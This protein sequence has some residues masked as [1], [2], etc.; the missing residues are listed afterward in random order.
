MMT[1]F[2]IN[3]DI[4]RCE[5]TL[6]NFKEIKRFADLQSGDKVILYP[7]GAPQ[8]VSN[9]GMDEDMDCMELVLDQDSSETE[10]SYEFLDESDEPFEHQFKFIGEQIT[11]GIIIAATSVVDAINKFAFIM[12]HYNNVVVDTAN[13]KYTVSLEGV[14]FC[15]RVGDRDSV[16]SHIVTCHDYNAD[17]TFSLLQNDA[18]FTA[19]ELFVQSD[20]RILNKVFTDNINETDEKLDNQL[21][22]L[23]KACYLRP[24]T[25]TSSSFGVIT[26]F[27]ET[28]KTGY[29][30]HINLNMCGFT[31]DHLK[32]LHSIIMNYKD[33]EKMSKITL[34]L[35]KNRLCLESSYD[36]LFELLCLDYIKWINISDNY[37]STVEHIA[38]LIEIVALYCDK[39]CWLPKCLINNRLIESILETIFNDHILIANTLKCA[40]TFYAEIN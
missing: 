23:P 31:D 16:C 20:S 25:I 5:P 32:Q 24:I 17:M 21:E 1:Y 34:S 2:E 10:Y 26:K 39:I 8:E 18:D 3:I 19:D 4:N 40:T 13:Y 35:N 12:K 27:I 7:N 14:D 36:Y 33:V 11:F 37:I 9:I 30:L 29:D 15:S 6:L 38:K 22:T 28:N